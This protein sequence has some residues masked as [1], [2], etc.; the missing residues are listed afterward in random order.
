MHGRILVAGIGNIFMGDD[1]FGVHV[2]Q[3]LARRDLPPEVTLVDYGIRG[4]DLAYALLE[5][6]SATIM[7]DAAQRGGE[8]GTLYIIEPDLQATDQA[9]REIETHAMHPANV[10]NLA[11]AMG[12]LQGSIYLVA[13]EPETFG[14]ENEGQMGLSDTVQGSVNEAA[15]MVETLVERILHGDLQAAAV[16]AM[17]DK[18]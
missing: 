11:R 10:I 14:P 15:W 12:D 4:F 6:Y 2:A 9:E 1:A 8:P 16:A 13:C 18:T 17:N 7:I 3:E 5:G